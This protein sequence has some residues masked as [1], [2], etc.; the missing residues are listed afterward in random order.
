M[1]YNYNQA[2]L[3]TVFSTQYLMNASSDRPQSVNIPAHMDSFTSCGAN[4]YVLIPRSYNKNDIPEVKKLYN[5]SDFV[6]NSSGGNVTYQ[7]IL[8]ND[9]VINETAIANCL[10]QMASFALTIKQK[11][12]QNNVSFWIGL[13]ELINYNPSGDSEQLYTFGLTELFTNVNSSVKT[14]RIEIFAK[15]LTTFIYYASQKF[16]SIWSDVKGFYYNQERLY[17]EDFNPSDLNSSG[18]FRLMDVVSDCIHYSV[19]NYITLNNPPTINKDFIWVP[20]LP[21]LT[22]GSSNDNTTNKFYTNIGTIIST[23]NVFDCVFLQAYLIRVY[24]SAGGYAEYPQNWD[25]RNIR[26]IRNNGKKNIKAIYQS[27]KHGKLYYKNTRNA[28][29]SQPTS[30]CLIGCEYELNADIEKL[31]YNTHET[32]KSAFAPYRQYDAFLNKKP[33]LFYWEAGTYYTDSFDWVI[34]EIRQSYNESGRISSKDF[35]LANTYDCFS[36]TFNSTQ[37]INK[38]SPLSTAFNSISSTSVTISMG[39]TIPNYSGDAVAKLFCS[40]YLSENPDKFWIKDITYSIS[41]LSGFINTITF[42]AILYDDFTSTDLAIYNNSINSILNSLS[43]T[44][45]SPANFENFHKIYEWLINN[46]NGTDSGNDDYEEICDTAYAAISDMRLATII[47]FAKALS[48]LCKAAGIPC[49][50]TNGEIDGYEHYWNYVKI[51]GNWWCVDIWESCWYNYRYRYFLRETPPTYLFPYNLPD[52]ETGTGT[53][54]KYGDVDDDGYITAT[55]ASMAY[56]KAI[57]PNYNL[58]AKAMIAADA[59]A[60]GTITSEDSDAIMAKCLQETPL[61]VENYINNIWT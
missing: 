30:N 24:D 1:A 2:R 8:N 25:T 29:I 3:V 7:N 58:N 35:T 26:Q 49:L 41:Y 47:G 50:V 19:F 13:P 12:G 16:S 31:L 17:D 44:S 6:K 48:V 23:T 56:Q 11:F 4:G 54:I 39:N 32:H 38:Y 34:N 22:N 57:N 14:K 40:T 36:S 59:T 21:A 61:P 27:V 10:E 51:D 20:Y 55:D 37:L 15:V 18:E 46:V 53:Y 43:I 60:T 5:V 28:V 33:M 52:I 9:Y 42:N 45:S